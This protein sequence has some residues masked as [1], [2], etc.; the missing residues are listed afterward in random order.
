MGLRA[1]ASRLPRVKD[2]QRALSPLF[3]MQR[4]IY[5]E[6]ARLYLKPRKSLPLRLGRSVWLG[7]PPVPGTTASASPP[8]SVQNLHRYLVERIS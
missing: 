2:E 8:N 3:R 7:I 4:L 1:S 6:D 5:I